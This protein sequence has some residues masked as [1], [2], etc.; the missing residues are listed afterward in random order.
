MV[1]WRRSSAYASRVRQRYPAKKPASASRSA[2]VNVGW[3]G[4]RAVVVAVI[5]YLPVRAETD[6]AGPAEASATIRSSPSSR[7]ARYLLSLSAKRGAMHC[8]R[9]TLQ[10]AES[11]CLSFGLQ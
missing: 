8:A 4:T 2:S 9:E 7:L 3:R 11:L 6:E 5:G 10:I 1:N